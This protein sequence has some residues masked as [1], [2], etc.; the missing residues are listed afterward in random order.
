M[1]SP[2]KKTLS[3]KT[4]YIFLGIF[5]GILG[6]F[7]V[8]M[9]LPALAQTQIT[10]ATSVPGTYGAT[11]GAGGPGAF[12]ANIYQFALEIG[13]ALAFAVVVYGGIKYLTSAG[14]PSAQ[15]DAKEWIES[16]LLGLLLL[17]GVFFILKVV[18]PQLVDLYL[19]PLAGV[20]VSG[21]NP[22]SGGGGSTGGS[23]SSGGA[24][25]AR[26]TAPASG[27]CS[28]ASLANTCMGANAAMAG[29]VCN[30]ESG[31]S[32]A[33]GGDLSTNLGPNGKGLPASVGLFQINLSANTLPGLNCPAAFSNPYTGTNPHTTIINMPLYQQCVAAAENVAT[34][35]A[36]ACALSKNGTNWNMWGPSTKTACGLN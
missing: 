17:V 30:V 11:T 28:S 16:A 19:P 5:L 26:C 13:G 6:T 23:G 7:V 18:N 21:G 8:P 31:G 27:P 14:N 2:F 20:S 35:I 9:V 25:S 24:P 34:N 3:K 32:A 1:T 29:G 33:A 22:V 12:V 4:K 15:S 10:V 36:K